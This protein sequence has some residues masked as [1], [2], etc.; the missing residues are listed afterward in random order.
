MRY[1]IWK[2][3]LHPSLP[4]SS[5]SIFCKHSTASHPLWRYNLFETHSDGLRCFI[6]Y[7]I[8]ISYWLLLLAASE[9]R[10]RW[11]AVRF[12]NPI[13]RQPKA[14]QEIDRSSSNLIN[15]HP[16][17]QSS[18]SSSS[19][20]IIRKPAH[21]DAS[22]A[23]VTQGDYLQRENKA[24]QPWHPAISSIGIIFIIIGI[25]GPGCSLSGYI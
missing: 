15:S 4:L 8:I 5:V 1:G 20:W 18:W 13:T 22:R 17:H 9:S 7:F 16:H 6:I 25:V 12:P 14:S 11:I 2:G 19:S 21:P 23:N 3:S 24:L 10:T